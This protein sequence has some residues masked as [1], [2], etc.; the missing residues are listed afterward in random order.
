VPAENWLPITRKD[1]ELDLI[2]RVYQP[3]L[4]KMK[5]WKEPK[6]EMLK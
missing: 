1:L 2:M 3:D 6:A 4:K 5:T